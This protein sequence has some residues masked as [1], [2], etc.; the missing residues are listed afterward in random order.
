MGKKYKI[1]ETFFKILKYKAASLGLNVTLGSIKVISA[2]REL[3]E[4]SLFTWLE[5][6]CAQP[7]LDLI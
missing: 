3:K 2:L 1:L 4:H 7:L 6:V 5:V